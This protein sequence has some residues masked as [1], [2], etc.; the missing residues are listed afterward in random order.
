MHKISSASSSDCI[1]SLDYRLS[2]VS[3]F[4]QGNAIYSYWHSALWNCVKVTRRRCDWTLHSLMQL[5]QKENSWIYR[6]QMS[7]CLHLYLHLNK[8]LFLPISVKLDSFKQQANVKFFFH[9]RIALLFPEGPYKPPRFDIRGVEVPD[10]EGLLWKT[11]QRS[12]MGII[13]QESYQ[14]VPSHILGPLGKL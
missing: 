2:R 3:Y 10:K 9:F 1:T 6:N 13:L 14:T 11:P 7:C 4:T 8:R 5:E 12:T